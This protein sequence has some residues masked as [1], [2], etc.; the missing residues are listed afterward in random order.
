VLF[1]TIS[2]CSN[3]SDSAPASKSSLAIPTPLQKLA[4]NDDE[5]KAYVVIDGNENN[6]IPMTLNRSGQG[7]ANVVI[8]SLS[9]EA[10][11]FVI[12]YEFTNAS[13]TIILATSSQVVDLTSGSD[14]ITVSANE[15]DLNTYDE[16]GD[17][18]NNAQELLTGLNPFIPEVDMA[19]STAIP[20]F[21]TTATGTLRALVV[22]D[23]DTANP[24]EM[25]ID[26][27]TGTANFTF[28]ALLKTP[29]NIVVTFEYTDNTGQL[30]LANANRSIDLTN[31]AVEIDIDINN[32]DFATLDD[33]DGV[34]NTIELI[35][36][37]NPRVSQAPAAP[38]IATLSYEPTKAFLFTWQDV[39]DA[40]YYQLQE[41][42][43]AGDNLVVIS[44]K[45]LPGQTFKHIV[46][47]ICA[48]KCGVYFTKL[49]CRRVC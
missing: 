41:R 18:E 26:A 40:T 47:L 9:R 25:D 30:I 17:G 31:G 45:I 16:D 11:G 32:N 1:S 48:F 22:L 37:L 43:D 12:T 39:P 23:G 33:E 19:I 4:V 5:L 8:P 29:H 34:S 24:I 21:S 36:G 44:D 13:G 27:T 14:S 49:Q 3:N 2:A 46:P 42:I 10:H 7:L 35:V 38:A 15:Y 6:R 28:D 20:A